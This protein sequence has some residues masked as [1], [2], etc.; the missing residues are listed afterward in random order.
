M[1]WG[2]SPRVGSAHCDES[3]V[4]KGGSALA[5]S[6]KSLP[7]CAVCPQAGLGIALAMNIHIR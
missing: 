2:G 7:N 5:P 4:N 6:R 1:I 3:E